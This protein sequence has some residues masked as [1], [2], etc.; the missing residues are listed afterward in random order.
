MLFHFFTVLSLSSPKI[1]FPFPF[2]LYSCLFFLSFS[3]FPSDHVCGF[4]D[5]RICGFS[6]DRG[7]VFDWT[8]QNHLSQNPKRSVNTGPDTDRS[9]TKEGKQS[10]TCIIES[11]KDVCL[12]NFRF[13]DSQWLRINIKFVTCPVTCLSSQLWIW[14]SLHNTIFLFNEGKAIDCAGSSAIFYIIIII[15]TIIIMVI[16]II[17]IITI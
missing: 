3:P 10:Y 13:H 6:Q 11:N 12:D 14:F 16:I 7:D 17:I 15:N 1:I 4:E 9:G 8:R 5:V 2:R